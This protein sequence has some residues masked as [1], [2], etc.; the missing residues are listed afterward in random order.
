MADKQ[1]AQ[2]VVLTDENG[3]ATW[4]GPDHP[5]NEVTADVAKQITNPAAWESPEPYGFDLSDRSTDEELQGLGAG[6]PDEPKSRS[7]R[8]SE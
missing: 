4:Y 7:R 3:V 1:L 2:N 6:R 8:T 5:G